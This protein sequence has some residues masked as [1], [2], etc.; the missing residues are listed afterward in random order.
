MRETEVLIGN[1]AWLW[2][3]YWHEADIGKTFMDHIRWHIGRGFEKPL[4]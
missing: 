2:D 3:E 4:A 1:S